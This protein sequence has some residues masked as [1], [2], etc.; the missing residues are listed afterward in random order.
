MA[1]EPQTH[2]ACRHY[3][4]V[5]LS[6]VEPEADISLYLRFHTM[7]KSRVVHTVTLCGKI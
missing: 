2:T 1:Y 6:H 3:S 7:I 4:W 5:G